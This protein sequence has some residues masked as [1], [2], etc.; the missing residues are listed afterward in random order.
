MKSKNVRIKGKYLELNQFAD[1]S[2]TRL[3]K[4]PYCIEISRLKDPFW[5]EH[6][7][8]KTWFTPAVEADFKAALKELK[9]KGK[10]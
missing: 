6:L 9:L 7:K 1:V 5:L 4:S 3:F 8:E 10:I 2:G